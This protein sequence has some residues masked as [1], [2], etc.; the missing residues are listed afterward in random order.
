MR[1]KRGNIWW[2]RFKFG[3]RIFEESTRTPSKRLAERIELKRR[4]ELEEGLHGLKKPVMPILFRIAAKDWLEWKAPAL[5]PRTVLMHQT[6]L[7]H[8]NKVLGGLLITDIEPVDIS[9]YQKARLNKDDHGKAKASPKTV[10]LEVATIRAVLR[11]HKL[12]AAIG[13]DVRMLPVRNDTGRALTPDEEAVLFESCAKSR[14]R[15]L[16]PFVVLALNTGMR[17][18]DLRLLQWQ[19][20]DLVGRMVT[21]GASKTEAGTGRRVPLNERAFKVVVTWAQSFPDRKPGHYVFPSEQYGIA[22]NARTVCISSTDPTTPTTSVQ[23]AWQLAKSRC[24]VRCRLHDLRHTACTRMLE[25]GVPLTVIASILGWSGSTMVLMAKRYGH[26]GTQAKQ[27]AVAM[28]DRPSKQDGPAPSPSESHAESS[29]TR[30]TI[31]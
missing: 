8:I 27:D 24:K 3:G 2:Y 5:A 23:E 18:S 12:W 29:D 26:I 10:N 21:V 25:A 9:N 7:A 14:S 16:Y 17:Y 1:W 30:G 31:N 28:L 11:R 19:Q 13:D 4:R 6:N 20:V 15:V 22:T